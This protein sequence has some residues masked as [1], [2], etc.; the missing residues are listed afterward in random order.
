MVGPRQPQA[1]SRA[2]GSAKRARDCR[3][4]QRHPH[5][6]PR[7]LRLRTL[8]SI[9]LS[10]LG[11]A[12][13]ERSIRS[14]RSPT[15]PRSFQPAK[16]AQHSTGLDT[17]RGLKTGPHSPGLLHAAARHWFAVRANHLDTTTT[18]CDHPRSTTRLSRAVEGQ[19]L[20]NRGNRSV[21]CQCLIDE[22]AC[23]GTPL[24]A[25]TW[26]AYRQRRTP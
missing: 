14:G 3:R 20:R 17:R 16:T 24:S 6:S 5:R 10:C 23:G 19:A 8:L 4:T 9:P 13:N 11:Y 15:K 21:R 12:S 2:Y 26:S 22:T 1:L 7:E 18:E 25:L